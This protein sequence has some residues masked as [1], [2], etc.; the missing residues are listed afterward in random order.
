MATFAFNELVSV[1][2]TR[3]FK[4]PLLP[5][6]VLFFRFSVDETTRQYYL[7]YQQVFINGDKI[8]LES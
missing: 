6:Y 1:W 7:I 5:G 8:K 4:I 2:I 3:M